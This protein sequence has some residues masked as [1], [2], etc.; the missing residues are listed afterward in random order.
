MLFSHTLPNAVLYNPCLGTLRTVTSLAEVCRIQGWGQYPT[1]PAN[2]IPYW[3]NPYLGN[4]SVFTPTIPV[5]LVLFNTSSQ[6]LLALSNFTHTSQLGRHNA[7]FTFQEKLLEFLGKPERVMSNYR[8]YPGISIL[9]LF[10]PLQS[11]SNFFILFQILRPL[12]LFLLV[13]LIDQ[14]SPRY[15]DTP[16][17]NT[18]NPK[19]KAK[20]DVGPTQI[21]QDLNHQTASS[22]SS[23]Q[24]LFRHS[25]R[26]TLLQLSKLA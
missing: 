17:A 4:T 21:F 11:S 24:D 8:R 3:R 5:L 1:I 19:A 20:A 9:L 12:P 16:I 13:F 10:N 6:H 23:S 26:F 7:M 15:P 25:N 2:T 22:F 14:T 18:S